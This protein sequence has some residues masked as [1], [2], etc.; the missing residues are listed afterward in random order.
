MHVLTIIEL[1]YNTIT[2]LNHKIQNPQN[3]KTHIINK[4]YITHI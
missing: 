3:I 2:Y 4:S 1:N